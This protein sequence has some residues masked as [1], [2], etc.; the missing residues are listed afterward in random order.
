MQGQ[1]ITKALIVSK[2]INALFRIK[3]PITRKRKVLYAGYGSTQAYV[4]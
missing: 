2:A 1:K 4:N 3:T